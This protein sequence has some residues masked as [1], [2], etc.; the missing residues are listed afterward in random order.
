MI[1]IA[2]L[3]STQYV[4]FE[5][6]DELYA[7]EISKVQSVVDFV[8]PTKVP[9]TPD[10]MSGVVNLRGRVVPIIDLRLKFGL[11]KCLQTIDSC[12]IMVEITLDE[13]ATI[14]GILADSVKAV[15]DLESDCIEPAPKIGTRL[16]TEFIK[17]MGKRE[18]SIIIILDLDKIFSTDEFSFMQEVGS[19]SGADDNNKIRTNVLL[20]YLTKD[21]KLLK[22][23]PINQS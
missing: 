18:N 4:T 22:F 1:D 12:I 17:G 5:L 23:P 8:K 16:K 11:S 6:D 14:M 21:K 20:V 19:T 10:F 3:E 15:I 9:K 7:L 13:E 2:N